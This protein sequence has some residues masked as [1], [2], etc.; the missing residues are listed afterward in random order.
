MTEGQL[1]R[2]M[3]D[4]PI[5]IVG[6]VHGELGALRALLR[7]LGYARGGRHP[8]GRR[9]VFVGD[10]SDRGPDSPGV[11][12]LVRRLVKLGN[13]QCIIGNHELNLLRRTKKDGNHWYFPGDHSKF[14]EKFGKCRRASAVE[15]RSILDFLSRLPIALERHDLRI[16][17]AAWIP[18]A[19]EACRRYRG[20]VLGAYRQFDR[21]VNGSKYAQRLR[22]ASEAQLT[23]VGDAIRDKSEHPPFLDAVARY[24]EYYQMSNPVRVLTSGA[25][26]VTRKPFY[27]G[28]KWRFVER[29]RWW[30]DYKGPRRVVFGHYWRWWDPA[31]HELLSKGEPYLFDG[32]G[33]GGWHRNRQHRNVGFCVDYSAGV[34]HKERKERG[35]RKERLSH[36]FQGRLAAL[37][38]PERKIVFDSDEAR[39]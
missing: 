27:A 22:A 23:R 25:E 19:V 7:K 15:R 33:P 28:G 14:E 17:H 5:D 3:F 11:I 12:A 10:L 8:E 30:R 31:S 20:T 35:K 9:L 39:G 24:D 32:D 4:G 13:A 34:R 18:D 37:R 26:R 36:H 29:E 2:P 1:I 21:T 38:W 6:D 16:V